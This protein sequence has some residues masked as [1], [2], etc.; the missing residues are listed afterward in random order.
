M[1]DR[2]IAPKIFPLSQPVIMEHKTEILPNG[3]ELVILHDPSQEVFK[4]DIMFKAGAAYQPQRLIATTAINM[5]GEG[6]SSHTSEQISELFD[7]YGAY[8]GEHVSMI[9]S[10]LCLIG[11]CKYAEP[12]INLTAELI[13]DSIFPEKEL[14]IFL[15]NRKQQFLIQCEK[16]SY[17]ARKEYMLRMYGDG[18]PYS[19]QVDAEDYDLLER[20][21]L[22]EFHKER[23]A[24]ENCKV[25]ISGNV[26]DEILGYIR[27]AFS[28]IPN[29]YSLNERYIPKAK[30]S[31]IGKYHVTKEKS[32]QNSIRIGKSGVKL[33]DPDYP[34]FMLLNTIFGGYFSSRLMANIREE[35]GYTYGI[36]SCNLPMYNAA[37]WFIATDVNKEMCQATI[38]ECFKEMRNLA[39]KPIGKEEFN[40]ARQYLHGELL[41]ELDG[42]FA[43]SDMLRHKRSFGLDLGLYNQMIKRISTCD[44]D[45]IQEL[46]A[47]YL[48]PEECYIITAG[49]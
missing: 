29:C 31:P 19:N 13:I 38:D 47:R 35:K 46:A 33:T 6:T 23:Y 39:E 7:Y 32:A 15:K 26:S 44:P 16:T 2:N 49:E 1:I 30:P 45:R 27:K 36:Q 14:G 4:V 24:A 8:I 12:V 43:Q 11:L 20:E 42:A 25:Y 40:R 34:E 10:E 48:R 3:V 18:H 28:E 17:L 41:R 22:V 21:L 5:L 37:N 9:N